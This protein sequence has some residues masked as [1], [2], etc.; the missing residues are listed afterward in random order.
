MSKKMLMQQQAGCK[1]AVVGLGCYYPG[2]NSPLQLWENILARRQQFREM[3]DVRLPNSEYFDPDPLVPNKTY[4]NK[5]AVLDGFRFDWLEKRIPKQ[6]YESTDIVHWL[7]LDTALQAMANSGYSK[8]NLPKEKTGVILGNTLTGEFTRSNQMLLRW[9]FVRKALRASARRKGLTHIADELEP[10]MEEHYKSVFA[11]VTEDTLAGGLANTIA[12]RICNYLDLHGGGYIVDGACSSSLLAVITA[13]NYLELGQMD[14]VIAGGVDISLDTFELIGF[15]K[16]GALTPDEMRVYDKAGKGFLPGEGCGMTILKRLE[17][18]QRDKDQIYAVIDGWGISS[19]GK[20]GITAPSAA[21]QSRALIRAHEKAG[22]QAEKLDFIE[23]HGTGTTVGDKVELEGISIALN[24]KGAIPPRNCGVTSFKSIVGHTKAA[25]GIG[26]LIKTVMAVNRRILPPTA[27]MKDPNPIFDDKA[28]ALYPITHGQVRDSASTIYAGVSAM[29]FGGIN[30]HVLMES[31][32]SPNSS[33]Q[34][35]LAEKKLL[36]SC[37]SHELFLFSASSREELTGA[38]RKLSDDAHGMSYGEMADLACLT[39]GKISYD[40]PLRAAIVASSPTDLTRKLNLLETKIN[41]WHDDKQISE[42]NSSVSAGIRSANPRIGVL[43]PGQGSQKL[44]MARKLTERHDW[45]M[46]IAEKA[47]EIFA[48]EGAPHVIASINRPINRAIDRNQ[49]LAWQHELKQTN[50]AQ[51]AITLASLIWYEYLTRLGISVTCVTGHSLGELTAFYVAGLINAETLLR[52]AAFR[53][54]SMAESGS[55][56]MASL[57][58]TRQQA[59]KYVAESSGYVTVANVNAPGQT[60][61]SGETE[62]V[63][64]V[65]QLAEKDQVGAI[66][67]PVSAAFHSKLVAEVGKAISSYKLLENKNPKKG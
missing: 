22:F 55:G 1:I 30:S 42:E 64:Q 29:G 23:G 66:E 32:S 57:Q 11:P 3:P 37:Q 27:G 5:A 39:N 45:L 52:F 60:V 59:E 28:T 40:K 48:S 58:C 21:G 51:P 9:P 7:A 8:E 4:Q 24:N 34:P 26:A 67:L 53:G 50:I 65:I 44:N 54:K 33:I 49:L 19:D 31:G 61:I 38:L 13:A 15:A 62:S 47:D 2:A 25:A 16:T 18:A 36:V 35:A 43:F 10:A 12:G 20:G 63:K 14:M 17:D 56:T 46:D 6:T 41:N